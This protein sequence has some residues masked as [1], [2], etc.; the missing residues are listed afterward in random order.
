MPPTAPP[1]FNLNTISQGISTADFYLTRADRGRSGSS[2]T[3]SRT[4]ADREAAAARRRRP[5]MTLNLGEEI[6]VLSTVFGAAAPGGFA[7]MPQSSF[8][9]SPV[10][11]NIEMTP[12][13]TYEGEII[14]DL[15]VESSALGAEHQRRRPGR[16]VVR[17]RARSRR[18]CACAKGSRTCSPVCCVTTS[19]SRCSGF[20]GVI[21]RAG[22]AIA[23]RVNERSDQPD[24]HRHAAD[25]AHRARRTS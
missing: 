15:T 7:S 25:A 5:K 20:P 9:Y 22:A 13:V 1:P 4:Q 17:R 11:V 16:A 6:P 23:L 14:L 3:D 8:N 10:G 19:A 2:S 18:S 21:A 24:R 12:R